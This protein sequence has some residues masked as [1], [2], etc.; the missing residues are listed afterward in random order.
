MSLPTYNAD[1]L[2]A[3]Q[4]TRDIANGTIKAKSY[5]SLQEMIDEAESEGLED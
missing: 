3:I 5:S 1:T 4:E 2:E